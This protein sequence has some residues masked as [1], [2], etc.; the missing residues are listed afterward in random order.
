MTPGPAL[1]LRG[2]PLAGRRVTVMGLGLFGGGVAT[3][4]ALA[5][6]GA[7]VTVTDR[8]GEAELCESLRA[9]E[10]LDLR[11]RLGGHAREDFE[12]AE[13]VV[14]NPA[15]A[16]SNDWLAA[17]RGAGAEVTSETELF[18][19]ACPTRAA[20][21]TGTQGKSTTCHVAASLL[22]SCGIRARLGGNIGHSL[23]GELGEMTP[24]DAVVLELSSY[25]LEALPADASLL[26]R[27]VA[28]VG[29]TNVL[30]DHLERHGSREAYEAAKRRI[31]ELAGPGARLVLP[32]DD[33]RVRAWEVPA[34]RTEWFRASGPADLCVA[35]GRFRRGGE[36]LGRA[37][38]LALPGAFQLDNALCA[39]GLARALG[40]EA[41]GLAAALGGVRGL[42]HRLEDLG[43]FAGHNVWDNGVSTTPDSTV[44]AL[45]ALSAPG[46]EGGPVALLCGGRAKTLPLE[47]LAAAA[48]A[49]T[50]RVVTFGESGPEL[51]RA[52]SAG[53]AE[54]AC[55]GD[56]AAA[57]REVF[58]RMEG[59]EALLFSPG[60]SSF[61]AFRNF[62]ERAAAFRAALP[63]RDP[64]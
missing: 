27:N 15:V 56:L 21:V 3:T 26:A 35:D 17:A 36:E 49:R 23:L 11:R 37:A 33:G 40:A 5:R 25:Q 30:A 47:P 58:G 9:L 22:S 12:G 55:A 42:A 54:A 20:L 48:A 24:G 43:V 18:L 53:G 57:V 63:G 14:A 7:R 46:V 34:E 38:D 61:D 29:V 41:V 51:A 6:A 1:T 32:A 62:A 10:G 16:P 45:E 64:A 8:R 2:R 52:L 60:C 19:E 39:L 28:A 59:G 4:R 13:V 50:S 44:S 31:L